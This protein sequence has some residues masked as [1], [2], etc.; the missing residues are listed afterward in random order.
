[1]LVTLFRF[2]FKAFFFLIILL[3]DTPAFGNVKIASWNLEN[4]GLK[5]NDTVIN[6]M[7]ASL[8]GF[9]IIAIQEVNAGPS[10][11]QALAKL[12][13]ALNLTGSKWDYSISDITSS[14]NPQERERYAFVWKTARI[15]P[16]GKP[17]LAIKWAAEIC[18]EPFV[19]TSKS[20]KEVF[21]LVNIHAIP[22]KKQPETELKYLKFLPEFYQPNRLIFLGDFNCPE[23]N[24]VFNP[25]KRLGFEPSLTGQKTS[26]REKWNNGDCLA[27]NYD[28]IFYDNAKFVKKTSGIIPFYIDIEWTT[29]RK[30]S[31]H[32]PIFVELE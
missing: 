28:N 6:I 5:K 10:G 32:V 30:V 16:V 13:D 29:A 21:T 14:D 3:A 24:S 1:V 4:F 31:D 25:L 18:R 9:D 2:C 7:A 17:S 26:L 19:G 15:K 22:K 11:S 23:S 12:V 27:S 20:K 8:K